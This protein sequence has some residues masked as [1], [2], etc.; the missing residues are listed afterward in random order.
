MKRI[1]ALFLALLLLILTGCSPAAEPAAPLDTIKTYRDIP[2][3]TD[4][5]KEAIE[6]LIAKKGG[7][8]YGACLATEAFMLSE[9]SIAG[10]TKDFCDLLSELFGVSFKVKLYDWDELMEGLT[11]G[12]IDFTG[13]LTP[14]EERKQIYSMTPPIAERMLRIFT[15]TDSGIKTEND[16]SDLKIGFL[17]DSITADNIIKEYHLSFTCVEVENYEA[18]AKMIESGEIDAFVDEAVADPIFS[19]Y[20]YIRSQVFFPMVH[21]P[22][23]MTAAD[24]E[25][26]PMIS[27]ISKY[28]EAGGLDKLYELYK[29]GDFKYS[30]NKLFQS[31]TIEERAYIDHLKAQGSVV[32]VGY[33]HDNYPVNFYNEKDGEYQGIAID[34]LAEISRYT[35]LSFEPAFSKEATWADIYEKL[36]S[37]EVHMVAQLLH[38][39]VRKDLFLWSDTP[40]ARSYYALMSKSDYPDLEPYQVSRATVGATKES[41]KIDIFYELFPDHAKV[42]EYDTQDEC[43]DA[44]ERGDIDLLMASEYMLLTQINYREKSGFKINIKL[45]APL[46]SYF[47]FQ[48]SDTVLCSIIDKAQQYVKTDVIEMNWTGRNFDYS[49]RL[50]EESA[51]SLTI[52]LIIMFIVLIATVFILMRNVKLTKQLKEMAHNDPLTGIYNRRFFMELASFQMARST[53]TN[54]ESFIIIYDL[55]HFKAVNDTYGHLAGDK[56]LIETSQRVKNAIRP[57]DVLGRYGGEEF[58]ILMTD[59]KE[60]NKDN[61]MHAIDRIRQ[62]ICK[63][64][65]VFEGIDISVSASFG[66]AYA[67]PFNDL[68]TAVKYAD[69]ALYSAKESGRNRVAF[70]GDEPEAPGL[71]AES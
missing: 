30:R 43:L 27:A 11:S 67:A 23:S 59:I 19:E 36:G 44:L 29:N 70:Y 38:S 55:D 25:L 26:A 57:Y 50:A 66:M 63:A 71:T 7:F 32:A 17:A 39:E 41:A 13:E 58:I 56:V 24:P 31:F 40:Y 21:N 46:D 18:A 45:D 6:N 34:T 15:R 28:I 61:A 8:T 53:R 20:G 48:K 42:I 9:G 47:G 14:T 60:T 62:E 22:V 2:N 35:G 10:F 64:P 51:R 4:V 69:E 5:E 65:V 33:E 52:F 12:T 1:M 16:V 54:I 37:G 3:V 49:K 68:A